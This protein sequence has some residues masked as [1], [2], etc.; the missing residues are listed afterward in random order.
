VC[1]HRYPPHMTRNAGFLHACKALQCAC[2][3]LLIWR[4]TQASYMHAKHCNVHVSSSSYDAQRR[5]LTCMQSIAMCML[6]SPV[7]YRCTHPYLCVCIHPGYMHIAVLCMHVRSLRCAS[8]EEED[9]CTLHCFACM[10][11]DWAYFQNVCVLHTQVTHTHS[12][13]HT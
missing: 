2:I 6:I 4:A 13:T 9:T 8:Y 12:D 10:Y 1:T 11:G 7:K 5:L 3:L